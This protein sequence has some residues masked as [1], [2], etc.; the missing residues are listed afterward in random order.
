MLPDILIV[1]SKQYPHEIFFLCMY[2]L[3]FKL[4]HIQIQYE[5]SETNISE[6]QSQTS[7]K[8]SANSTYSNVIEI[9]LILYAYLGCYATRN[10]H[11]L[12]IRVLVLG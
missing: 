8:K 5:M 7:Y 11:N 12:L 6:L 10:C 3:F 9:Q 4:I 1:T 2:I